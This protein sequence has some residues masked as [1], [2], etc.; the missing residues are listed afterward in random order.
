LS[1]TLQLQDWWKGKPYFF[2][3]VYPGETYKCHW[4]SD[5]AHHARKQL[6]A[7]KGDVTHNLDQQ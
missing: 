1:L 3:G 7:P 5:L 6:D 4:T 2:E